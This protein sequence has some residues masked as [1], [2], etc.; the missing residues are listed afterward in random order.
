M[1]PVRTLTTVRHSTTAHNAARIISGRLDEPLSDDGRTLARELRDLIG[2]FA[3][4]TVVSSPMRRALETAGII[5]TARGEEIA[6]SDLCV[7]RDYGVLQGIS[8]EEVATYADQITYVEAGGIRHSLNPPGGESFEQVRSRAEGLLEY[9]RGLQGPAVLV[10][11]HQTFLQQ[12]HGLLSGLGVH[13]ALALDI[14]TLQ[15]DRFELNGT[16]P[17]EHEAVHPGMGT[18]RSW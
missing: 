8:P 3:A 1:T 5:T 9:V 12:L 15:V 11:A 10:V 7:E 18:H 4:D 17:A 14:R 13:E 6:T 2:P 16:G